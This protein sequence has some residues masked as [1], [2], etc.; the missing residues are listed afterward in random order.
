MTFESPVDKVLTV[1]FGLVAEIGW[2]TWKLQGL[3]TE[4]EG[5]TSSTVLAST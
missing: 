3:R 5:A 2:E 4:V 1:G